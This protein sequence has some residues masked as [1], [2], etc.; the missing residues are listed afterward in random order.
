MINPEILEIARTE[1]KKTR[2]T[3]VKDLSVIRNR[4]GLSRGFLPYMALSINN[5]SW[6]CIDSFE[7]EKIPETDEEKDMCLDQ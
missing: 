1:Y 6:L 3:L 4:I 7:I 2:S 5:N